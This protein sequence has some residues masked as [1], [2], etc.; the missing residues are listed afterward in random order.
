[1]SLFRAD[2]P[3]PLVSAQTGAGRCLGDYEL[4]EE[5]ARG[6]M[7]IVYRARQVSLNRTVAVKLMRD[8]ALAG[9]EEV[10]RFKVEAGAAAKLKHPNI[11]A[12]HEVGEQDGQHYFAMDLIE[13]TNLSRHTREGPLPPRA[14]AELVATIAE[15][16]QH[17]HGRGV[18]HRDLKPSN[19][20]LDGQGQPFVTDFGLARSLEAD[21][22]LTLTGQ[23]L[24]TPGY[25]PPEQ[26]TGLGTVGPAADIYSLGAV[27]YHL[28]TGRAPFVG[29]T[30]AETMRHV[31]EQEP[32]SPQ[33]VNPEV[34]RDLTSVCLKCLAKRPGD[35]YVS[36]ADLSAD[37]RRFLRGEPTQARPAGKTERLVRWARRK[38]LVASL[39]SAVTL[40]VLLFSVGSPIVAYRMQLARR[41]ADSLRTRAES[42]EAAARRN[43]YV[44]DMNLAQ[45]ALTEFNFRRVHELLDRHRPVADAEDL[46]EFE[47]RYLWGVARS[48]ELY[49][50]PA[51]SRPVATAFSPDGKWLAT[52]SFW[53]EAKLWDAVTHL[54]TD[55]VVGSEAQLGLA[56]SSDSSF[57]IIPTTNNTIHVWDI[58]NR[59]TRRILTN[60]EPAFS[61][62][63]LKD[64]QTVILAGF[65]QISLWNVEA[66][67]PFSQWPVD[68]MNMLT[69]GF[70][71]SPDE[72]LVATA[73]R[74]QTVKVWSLQDGSLVESLSGA[75]AGVHD[76]A[77][78]PDG[79]F[80]V[81]ASDS[82]VRRW[83][84]GNRDPDLVLTNHVGSAYGI[85]ISPDGRQ[86]AS[87]GADQ[88]V[89]LWNAETGDETSALRG[90]THDIWSVTYTPDGQHLVTG[91]RN[92]EIKFW[93][94]HSH[95]TQR[96][97][98]RLP[99]NR[100][101][102]WKYSADSAQL[103]TVHSDGTIHFW[104]A[105][106]L[107]ETSVESF[108]ESIPD[109]AAYSPQANLVAFSD[110]D[111]AVHLVEAKG[112]S[113][114]D[115]GFKATAPL[116]WLGFSDDGTR[117]VAASEEITTVWDVVADRI[118]VQL[119]N[120]LGFFLYAQPIA[121][122]PDGQMLA[123]GDADGNVS[124]HNFRNQT[125]KVLHPD[126]ILNVQLAFAPDSATLA[127]LGADY[128]ITLWD[129]G[130]LR[131]TAEFQNVRSEPRYLAFSPDG[132][133][134]AIA[135]FQKIK[136]CDLGTG[137]EV[138]NLSVGD[139]QRINGLAFAPNG[140]TLVATGSR[141]FEFWRA[142]PLTEI[143]E[144][145]RTI[146][147]KVK[148]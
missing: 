93:N 85:A 108:T 134:L 127:I 20:L 106:T 142:I 79:K 112:K 89:R 19:V 107:E 139:G 63:F 38:P 8:G 50:L 36:A 132:R 3:M 73:G 11:V 56:F 122:T 6:G 96:T 23:V 116:Q 91:S 28:L 16:V 86:I 12:I 82:G 83:V 5:I 17:A 78:S 58:I 40:L 43:L 110:S 45:Q 105:K 81:A 30:P 32:V 104:D 49:H 120:R 130:E 37:L 51:P 140:N 14:A 66:V 41:N 33:L 31:V 62:R 34:P 119:T 123:L 113:G 143:D 18:L 76:L 100:C 68:P 117:L 10:R 129:T 13:G 67:Q 52:A 72:R 121:L 95:S 2:T 48:D 133:R 39:A 99:G 9:A 77:F 92:G 109:R 94:P 44:A 124:I 145:S 128:N 46:R 70:A 71:V 15:A 54:T 144:A 84:M 131:K 115:R 126:N 125:K 55:I 146:K 22:S 35:R 27:L 64:S 111:G 103:A 7:G 137:Q 136:L 148:L 101:L 141:R 59:R 80:M 29:G 97:S 4:Q 98:L 90:H 57:L 102:S 65:K 60:S 47:W 53:A 114:R 74:G 135:G 24:G 87:T 61:A 1:M 138:A 25:M 75:G 88:L 42:G 118:S 69:S 26:A 21:S 147:R